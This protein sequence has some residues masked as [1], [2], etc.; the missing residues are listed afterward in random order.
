VAG[1]VTTE[2]H[3]INIDGDDLE[4]IRVLVKVSAGPEPFED[5]VTIVNSGTT[6]TVA[7]TA[8][9]MVVNDKIE[10]SQS[11]SEFLNRGVQT[12]SAVNGVNEYEYEMAGT[13]GG[14]PTGTITV[15]LII[16]TGLT[17]VNGL[18]SASRTFGSN[19]P[20]IGRARAATTP[21]FYV[22]GNLSGVIDT[23]SG[24]N[25]TIQMILDQ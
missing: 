13:P 7:H 14:S 1:A 11:A 6:A 10:V 21:P 23:G 19:Q 12:I 24:L 18:I 16:L 25:S 4:N 22:T 15:T 20:V 5:V 8:H 3:V 9:G 17:D 2:V